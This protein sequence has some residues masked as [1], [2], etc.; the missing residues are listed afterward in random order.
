TV[1]NPKSRD[2]DLPLD[3]PTIPKMGNSSAAH[4]GHGPRGMRYRIMVRGQLIGGRADM[5][6][7]LACSLMTAVLLIAA[8]PGAAGPDAPPIRFNR[9]IRPILANAC[10][11]CHGPDP[12]GRKGKLRIDREEGFFGAREGGPTIV[13]NQPDKS[14]L[15]LRIMTKDPEEVMPPPKSRKTLK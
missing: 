13:K 3:Y 4:S 11:Q 8:G 1:R 15:Y 14:P 6:R 12:G 7:I 10:F 2:I 5:R 9:D